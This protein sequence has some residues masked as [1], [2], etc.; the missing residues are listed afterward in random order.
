[1]SLSRRSRGLR[2][3]V[4]ALAA[5]LAWA[6]PQLATAETTTDVENARALFV[7]ATKLGKEGRWREARDLYARS[8]QLKPAP[9]TRYSLGVAQR[10]TGRLVHALNSFRAFLAEPSTPTT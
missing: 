7:A 6:S 1:M 8:L 5:A 2:V 9:L 4:M 3:G 10:E